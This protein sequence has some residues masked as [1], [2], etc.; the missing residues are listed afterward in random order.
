MAKKHYGDIELV[1]G[2]IIN[3]AAE[4]VSADPTFNA[5][6]EGLIIFNTTDKVYK[7]NNGT[8]W[9]TFEVSLTSTNELVDSLGNNWINPDFSFDPSDFNSLSN[10]SGLSSTDS[11]YEVIVELNSAID[12]AKNVGTLQ[13]IDLNFTSGSV[14]AKNIIY[15]DGTDFVAGTVNDLDT[16]ELNFSQLQD[17]NFSN[18]GNNN[19]TVYQ[20]SK[21]VNKPVFFKYNELSGTLSTFTVNH[22]LGEQFC[23]VTIIDRSFATPR[24]I[25]PS[26]ISSIEYNSGSTLTVNLTTTKPVTIIVSGLNTV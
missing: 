25:N 8:A 4:S 3:L 2:A 1:N 18:L 24:R 22:S 16:V 11:L 12:D 26:L 5:S 17:T 23:N 6:D 9:I 14:V 15:F 7:Y 20:G 19:F 13:G 10:I 21:W